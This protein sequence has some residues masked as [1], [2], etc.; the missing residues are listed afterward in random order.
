MKASKILSLVLI[1][2]VLGLSLGIC[3]TMTQKE[4]V[5][6]AEQKALEIIRTT[7]DMGFLLQAQKALEIRKYD[8]YN[9]HRDQLP[10]MPAVKNKA[11]FHGK[12]PP[13]IVPHQSCDCPCKCSSMPRD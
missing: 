13:K 5:Q 1:P 7:T 2:G 11:K 12:R 3:S 6:G 9:A 4:E 10:V 8:L